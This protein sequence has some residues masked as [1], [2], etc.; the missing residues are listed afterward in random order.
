MIVVIII[1]GIVVYVMCWIC[2]GSGIL[3]IS[4]VKFVVLD[5]GDILFLNIVFEIIIFVVSFG[6]ILIVVFMLNKVIFIVLMV[7]NEFFVNV[8]INMVII[9]VLIKKY[10]GEI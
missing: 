1:F 9:K 2:L 7:V 10:W 6:C 3:M 4:E 8:E 5:N